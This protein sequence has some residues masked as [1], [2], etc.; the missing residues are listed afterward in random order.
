MQGARGQVAFSNPL[1]RRAARLIARRPFAATSGRRRLAQ[2][3]DRPSTS[4]QDF[5]ASLLTSLQRLMRREGDTFHRKE[6]SS[7]QQPQQ[8]QQQPAAAVEQ[9]A[10]ATQPQQQPAATTTQQ[11]PAATTA[12]QQPA[13]TQQPAAASPEP[14]VQEQQPVSFSGTRKSATF[15]L[16]GG[17][18]PDAQAALDTMNAVRADWG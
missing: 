12:Q 17:R 9:P 8:P 3:T 1:A 11:Q 15:D 18:C 7:G 14:A 13:V 16:G 6:L 10:V 4:A 2:A 5:A